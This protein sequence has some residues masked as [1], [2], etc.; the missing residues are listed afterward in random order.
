MGTRIF[1]GRGL[2]NSSERA[3]FRANRSGLGEEKVYSFRSNIF[4]IR[5]MLPFPDGNRLLVLAADTVTF[6]EGANAYEIDL[7][8]KSMVD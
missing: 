4:P 6:L 1:Y 7:S 5:R 8:K 2:D 3:I